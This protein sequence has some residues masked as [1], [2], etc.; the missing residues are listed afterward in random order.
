[1]IFDL[2]NPN[3]SDIKF[4]RFVFPDGQDHINIDPFPAK[5]LPITASKITI[6]TRLTNFSDLGILLQATEVLRSYG[7]VIID[8]DITYLLAARM[9]RRMSPGEPSTLKII[10]GLLNQQNYRSVRIFDPHSTVALTLI[11]R[12]SSIPTFD[13]ISS[14]VGH[15]DNPLLVAPDAGAAGKVD[16][17]ATQLFLDVVRCTK[18]RSTANGYLSNFKVEQEDLKGR[19]CLI[20]DDICDGG[21]TFI[22]LAKVL[23]EHNAGKLYLAVS[24]GIFSKGVDVLADFERVFSTNS[25]KETR[26]EKLTTYMIW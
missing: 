15:I 19:N 8:L 4:K 21:G 23:K 3:T 25:Y 2:I 5:T 22:G 20:V 26:H 14:V 11:D 16:S 18:S 13:F 24:H 17:L 6:V 9:D 10:A 12:S 7:F 1:M